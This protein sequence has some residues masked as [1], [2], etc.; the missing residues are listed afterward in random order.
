MHNVTGD[1]EEC[2]AEI[3]TPIDCRDLTEV[4][5]NEGWLNENLNKQLHVRAADGNDVQSSQCL[6]QEQALACAL[7]SGLLCVLYPGGL[8]LA[9]NEDELR[10]FGTSIIDDRLQ[11]RVRLLY[12]THMSEISMYI[13]HA[14]CQ[15]LQVSRPK[16][17]TAAISIQ[18]ECVRRGF[19]SPTYSSMRLV[20]YPLGT[21]ICIWEC[22]P[23]YVRWP[24]NSDPLQ[25][26]TP[27]GL[28]LSDSDA[29]LTPECKPIPE[30]FIAVEFS[31]RSEVRAAIVI[32]ELLTP[33]FMQ[34]LNALA[35]SFQKEFTIANPDIKD[36]LV[37]LSVAGSIYHTQD[38]PSIILDSLK[39][40]GYQTSSSI[41]LGAPQRRA[42]YVT[43]VEIKGI[44][45][46]GSVYLSPKAVAVTTANVIET[47]SVTFKPPTATAIMSFKFKEVSVLSV[48]EEKETEEFS[49]PMRDSKS[50][51]L[52]VNLM[53]LA[54]T[55]CICVQ[56][57]RYF[58]Q[59]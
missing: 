42:Q 21:E 58:R 24:W 38:L 7:Q 29:Q 1:E 9:H 55:L 13:V 19:R 39:S 17:S 16:A 44:V 41:V 25:D 57:V 52:R 5:Q 43:D 34:T 11:L 47:V 8:Q 12:L 37:L 54:L 50:I 20:R 10:R 30:K 18:N 22:R 23:D 26:S 6:G 31:L 40:R 2:G 53:V 49:S 56:Y 59:Q 35:L 45:I 46:I 14:V 33:E 27:S 32:P 36:A 48:V 4:L 3:N 15:T 51:F 28:P